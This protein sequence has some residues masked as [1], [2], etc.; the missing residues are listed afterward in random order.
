[1]GRCLFTVQQRDDRRWHIY[2]S[3]FALSRASFGLRDDAVEYAL[4]LAR[5]KPEA[6]VQVVDPGGRRESAEV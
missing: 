1:M 5:I 4:E 2:E 3:G 6:K